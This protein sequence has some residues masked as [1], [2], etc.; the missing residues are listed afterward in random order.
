MSGLYL[1]PFYSNALEPH[2]IGFLIRYQE[3]IQIVK[4]TL[5]ISNS[6]ADSVKII[7][8]I[9]IFSVHIANHTVNEHYCH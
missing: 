2:I 5:R 4:I 8:F 9:L 6:R 1:Y 7:S 3:S